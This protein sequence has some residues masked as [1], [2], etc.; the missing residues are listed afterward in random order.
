MVT[1][2]TKT[3]LFFDAEQKTAN[4]GIEHFNPYETG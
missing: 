1:Q 2:S 3:G 4:S